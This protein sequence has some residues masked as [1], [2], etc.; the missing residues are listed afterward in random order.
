MSTPAPKPK[1]NAMAR[2]RPTATAPSPRPDLS[3]AFQAD[4]RAEA[5][6]PTRNT[7]IDLPKSLHTWMKRHAFETEQSMKNLLTMALYHQRAR[8]CAE[9]A[10]RMDASKKSYAHAG[11]DM[12]RVVA[13]VY[14]AQGVQA[15]VAV[16]HTFHAIYAHRLDGTPPTWEK[17]R[18]SL[19]LALPPEFPDED[20]QVIADAM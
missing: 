13:E 14:R 3:A 18:Q 4:P 15:A 10:A 7:S 16:L 9:E 12:G 19:A 11:D 5:Q 8:L 17:Q 2:K 6:E 20:A 1:I